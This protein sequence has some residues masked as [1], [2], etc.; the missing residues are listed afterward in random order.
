MDPDQLY[1]ALKTMLQQFKVS[2]FLN[3]FMSPQK[4]L[5]D[6]IDSQPVYLHKVIRVHNVHFNIL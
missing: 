6:V 4:R 3:Y 2:A 5:K 1:N